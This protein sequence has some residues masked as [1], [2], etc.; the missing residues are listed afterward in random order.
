MNSAQQLSA[1]LVSVITVCLNAKHTI[2]QTL[3]SVLGQSYRNIEYI[4]IDGESTDGTIDIIDEYRDRISLCI[5]EKDCGI[6]DAFNKGIRLAHGE[7]IQLLN[8]DDWLPP[9]KIEK[10]VQ[11]LVK[12]PETGF[13]FGNLELIGESGESDIL[14]LGDPDYGRKIRYMM[15]RINHPTVLARRSVYDQCGLFDTCWKIAMDYEWFLRISNYGVIGSYDP[16]IFAYMRE[17]G[18]SGNW[19]A[20]LREDREVAIHH[21]LSRPVAY[22]IH[23][24]RYTKVAFRIKAE[25]FLPANL[26]MAFRPGKSCTHRKV[27]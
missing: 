19:W 12:T 10:S 3:E 25:R 21:G 11:N 7:Y 9:D 24:F 26:I 13:V 18:I 20:A 14:I 16:E 23:A 5:S 17:G 15:P 8:A 4:I 1:P 6:S 2:R 22:L 27:D